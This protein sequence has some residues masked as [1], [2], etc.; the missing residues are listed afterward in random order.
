[1]GTRVI[2]WT[3]YTIVSEFVAATL[4]FD[5]IND[6]PDFHVQLQALG[7]V[8]EPVPGFFADQVE[9]PGTD[10][11]IVLS[12][13]PLIVFNLP[14]ARSPGNV[15]D[16][17]IGKN[18]FGDR[19]VTFD[20]EPAAML[21]D[22]GP[23]MSV[24]DTALDNHDWASAAASASFGDSA[25]WTSPASPSLD[26]IAHVE[27]NAAFD[28]TAVV[29]A[30]AS[31]SALNIIGDT[32][33]MTVSVDAAATL[34]V[35]GTTIITAGGELHMN[36]GTI[37]P[38]ATEIRGGSLTGQGI[39]A[40]EVSSQGLIAPGDSTGI[41]GFLGNV[42]LLEQST[43]AIEIAG[44]DNSDSENP[45]FDQLETA[46]VVTIDGT[47]TLQ[48]LNGLAAPGDAALPIIDALA[49]NGTF[50]SVPQVNDGNGAGHLGD[51]V[52]FEGINY[53]LADVTVDVYQAAL[54]DANGDRSVTIIGDGVTFVSNLNSG[55]GNQG[56][57]QG[58][59]DWLD[60]DFND[61]TLVDI[62]N[63]GVILVAELTAAGADAA[64][65]EAAEMHY[66]WATGQITFSAFGQITL[67]L[68]SLGGNL[69]AG[70]NDLGAGLGF[71]QSGSPNVNAWLN[72][73]GFFDDNLDA[74][75]IISPQTH[76]SDLVFS[77]QNLGRQPVVGEVFVTGFVPEPTSIVLALLAL[78][79]LLAHGRRRRA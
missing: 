52:F 77:Y 1:M 31:V 44:T 19:T 40:G 50:A 76:P 58:E 33:E 14:D 47:L 57:A 29:S 72:F 5:V 8:T 39:V 16:G 45:Q 55:L 69:L 36:G 59:K 30:D 2:F 26:W 54:G 6:Q 75:F 37:D 9:L 12:N 74:G 20:P 62:V 10:G 4:G 25:S 79:C 67:L 43:L 17:L 42:D 53:N 46:G 22:P 23:Y 35:F 13:V 32:E 41:L 15:L 7:G 61:D 73:G 71:D 51:G 24:S 21:G 68:E 64:I 18:L 34:T 63:D 28:Q 38:F 48:A 56:H 66:D 65:P 70:G 60:A 11:G 3:F 49:V 27:N 78:F